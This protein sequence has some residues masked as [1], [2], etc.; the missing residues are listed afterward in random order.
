MVYIGNEILCG[1]KKR[2]TN[3]CNNVAEPIKYIKS[4]K[5]D[6]KDHICVIP[7]EWKE[8][9]RTG[10]SI[11]T[12]K[13]W[14]ERRVGAAASWVWAFFWGWWKCFGTRLRWQLHNIVHVL[15]ANQL[16]ILKWLILC[17]KNL[18]SKKYSK[19]IISIS[20]VALHPFVI[21]LS[22]FVL[23]YHMFPLS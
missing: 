9:S 18:L 11:K 20:I 8:I 13:D 6:T 15:N 1:Q 7:S 16:L 21:N 4:R 19:M 22:Y 23:S 2:S 17:Y 3:T 12:E 14:Q 5:P 10:K